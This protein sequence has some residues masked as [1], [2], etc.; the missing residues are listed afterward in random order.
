M[1]SMP[2]Q[3]TKAWRTHNRRK[4]AQPRIDS[5][6]KL[7]H[8]NNKCTGRQKGLDAVPGYGDKTANHGRNICSADTK[9]RPTDYWVRNARDLAGL[10]DQ[11]AEEV[12]YPNP[13]QKTQQDLP[14]RQPKSE[15]TPRE[16]I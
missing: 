16:Y 8:Y 10:S 6:R 5:R 1:V 14:A 12:D 9:R 15:Q 2:L 4:P 7:K 13:N 3:N 11:V